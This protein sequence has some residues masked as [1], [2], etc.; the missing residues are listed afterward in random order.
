MAVRMPYV[1]L[2]GNVGAGKS[3]LVEKVTGMTGMSSSASTSVTKRSRVIESIDGSLM[4]CD[5]PGTNSIT[6]QFSSNVEVA[7]ALD[8]MP[9][10]LVLVTVKADVR[11]ES[12]AKDLREYMECF[13]PEDF[14]IELIGFCITHMDTVIW[15]ED[16]L[17]HCLKSDLGIEKV[18]FSF[19]EKKSST[20]IQEINDECLKNQP[21]SIDIDGEIFLKLFKINN[22]E[23]KILRETRKE[24]KRFEKIKKDF[25]AQQKRYTEIE[26]KDMIF[27]FQAWMC[28]QIV[29][30]QRHLSCNNN[31]SFTGGPGIANE[32]G[33]IANLTNQLR[34]VLRDV[35]I[36]AMKY[37]VDVET[38]FRKCPYCGEIWQKVEGCEGD[39]QCGKRPSEKLK[40]DEVNGGKMANFIFSWNKK[41]QELVTRKISRFIRENERNCNGVV[42]TQRGCGETINWSK[43]APVKVPSDFY[44][45]DHSS[46]KD[47]KPIP[48]EHRG[49]WE[50]HF[51]KV[52]KQR[53][54]LHITKPKGYQKVKAF[55]DFQA[56]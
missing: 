15:G 25:Y 56:S 14:P 37:H 47:V 36:E 28:D 38:D 1:I 50:N 12:V 8:F 18:I 48:E 39:T 10:D 2:I 5:T 55:W 22:N 30:T 9:V 17:I 19:P 32:A 45:A 11:I 54:K 27:E 21:V 23:I 7:R 33:H 44:T 51:E 4:I 31:F 46:T 16:E 26:Q 13:L 3:T 43:M 41:V 6:D 29:E 42:A 35:R 52:L 20:L 34:Q 49:A 24:V 53:G 40:W